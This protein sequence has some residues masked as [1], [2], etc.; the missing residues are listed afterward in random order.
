MKLLKLTTNVFQF[1]AGDIIVPMGWEVVVLGEHIAI[2]YFYLGPDGKVYDTYMR[3][4][5]LWCEEMI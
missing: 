5:D 2:K 4:V 1:Q 3:D